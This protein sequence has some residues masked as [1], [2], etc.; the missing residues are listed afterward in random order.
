MKAIPRTIIG[1]ACFYEFRNI[2][3][4][5]LP[6][7]ERQMNVIT[8]LVNHALRG[9]GMADDGHSLFSELFDPGLDLI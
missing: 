4:L 3:Y 2:L 9:V 1:K 6:I 5:I 8:Q 7:L